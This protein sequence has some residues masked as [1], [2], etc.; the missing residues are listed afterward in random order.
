VVALFR[1][2]KAFERTEYVICEAGQQEI[3]LSDIEYIPGRTHVLV[4]ING[5]LAYPGIDYTFVGT[6]TIRLSEPL[7]ERAEIMC[8]AR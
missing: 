3:A 4:Y 1:K 5:L 8:V 2:G 7:P 6:K